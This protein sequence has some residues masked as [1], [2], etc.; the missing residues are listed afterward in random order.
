MANFAYTIASAE[1]RR[2][3]TVFADGEV[4]VAS[5][6][7]EDFDRI[8]TAA[9]AGDDSVLEMFDLVDTVTKRFVRLTDRVSLVNGQ[10]KFDNDPVDDAVSGVILRA[11]ENNEENWAPLVLFLENLYGNPNEHSR[12]QA[13]RWLATHAFKIAADGHVLGYKSVTADFKSIHAGDAIVD[14]VPMSGKIPNKVG[15]IVEMPRSEVQFDPSVGCHTGLHIGTYDF[16]KNF[17][18]DT[19]LLVKFNPRDIVSVPTDA[20]DAKVRVCRYEVV[21]VVNDG[22]WGHGIQEDEEDSGPINW[23]Y[24]N[25]LRADELLDEHDTSLTD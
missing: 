19:M 2:S 13:Y 23:N 24:G 11:I 9:T 22:R 21:S 18:G 20:S 3:I 1:G 5:D 10:I 12:T 17:S 7:R 15:S 25:N 8:V 14:G 16:A 6:D 4:L